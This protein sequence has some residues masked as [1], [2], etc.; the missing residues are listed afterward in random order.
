M[1]GQI[2]DGQF[3]QQGI[4]TEN[5]P[6]YH[7]FLREVLRRL[8]ATEH[9]EDSAANRLELID[10]WAPWLVFPNRQIARMGDSGGRAVPLTEDPDDPRCIGERCFAVADLSRS[11]Y[12]IVRSLPSGD[13]SSML[14]VIGMAHN[15]AHKH[16]DELSFEL[17]E[18]GRFIFADSGKY[19]Y[20]KDAMRDYVVSAAAHNTVS[21]ADQP[22]GP[23]ETELTGSLLQPV[24]QSAAGFHIEGEVERRELFRQH[25][26][27]TYDPGVSLAI[28]DSL[29]SAK[30]RTYVSSLHLAPDL[31]PR[32]TQ[33]G[34]E[35]DVGEATIVVELRSDGCSLSVARG[36]ENPYLGWHSVGYLKMT[37][38]NV[39]RAHCPGT[40]R[41]IDW[42]ISLQ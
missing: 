9:L 39:L 38:T 1:Y 17:F 8:T 25:R 20:N 4:H 37:P 35:I 40:Q 18:H 42:H 32:Q 7:F 29:A 33:R 5:S 11:G 15:H 13:Q 2:M 34:F 10:H 21:L 24:R 26:S 27:I 14:F 12:A 19:G 3:T 28:S 6:D 23:R 31:E 16:A 36:Q 22:V 30:T 41:Q